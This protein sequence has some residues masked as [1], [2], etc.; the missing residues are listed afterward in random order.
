MR[1]S[2]ERQFRV[3]GDLTAKVPNAEDVRSMMMQKAMKKTSLPLAFET[4]VGAGT[5]RDQMY[6]IAAKNLV[7]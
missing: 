6:K 2:Q 4:V 1:Y 7:T 3:K 5:K